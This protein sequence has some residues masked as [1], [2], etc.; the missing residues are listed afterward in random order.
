ML[1][2]GR[3]GFEPVEEQCLKV[4]DFG[5]CVVVEGLLADVADAGCAVEYAAEEL[6]GFGGLRRRGAGVCEHGFGG[7]EIHLLGDEVFYVCERRVEDVVEVVRF[8]AV[9]VKTAKE[10]VAPFINESRKVVA[11]LEV[12]HLEVGDKLSLA[13]IAFAVLVFAQLCHDIIVV[14]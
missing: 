6:Y 11:A 7:R 13:E 1:R 12:V 10:E 2:F 3:F 14:P 9:A 8:L 4:G 5:L